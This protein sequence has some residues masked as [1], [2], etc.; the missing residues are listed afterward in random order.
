MQP[1]DPK[2]FGAQVVEAVKRY[3]EPLAA[4]V[5]ALEA[6]PAPK[7]GKDGISVASAQVNRDGCLILTLSDGKTIDVG[8]V[9][10][11]DGTD[12]K[13]GT[14]GRDGKDGT[15][16]AGAMLD[17]DGN[18]ILT[19]SNGEA[20]NIGRVVGKDGEPGRDGVGFDDLS[21]EYDG[22]RSFLLKFKRGEIE[23]VFRIDIPV[24]LYRGVF[25]AGDEYAAGDAVTWGGSLW[26]ATEKTSDKPGD[27]DTPWRLAVKRGRDGKDGEKGEKGEPGKV[28]KDARN[29]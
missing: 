8:R 29:T 1:I 17:R 12:G 23:K 10:G 24:M 11:R 5:A 13:D 27:G 4:R 2:A 14:D 9:E 21:V 28:V 18:L 16:V 7:D 3:V 20:K 25:K 6:R 26:I 19:L 15:G 22:E